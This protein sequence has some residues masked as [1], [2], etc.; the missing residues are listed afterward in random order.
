M[1]QLLIAT[2]P[3]GSGNHLWSKIFSESVKVQGWSELTKEYWVGHGDEPFV[4]V[5]E[6]PSIFSELEWPHEYYF[7]SI[8][9]PYIKIGGPRLEDDNNGRTP[10]YKEFIESAKHA[11]FNVSVCIIG[12]DKN[13]LK[14]Q[15]LRLRGDHTTS[16]LLDIIDQ[17][18]FEYNP[19]FLSTELL[20]LYGDRYLKSI[21]KQLNFPI[22]VGAEK[23]AD[24]L[25]DNANAK[26]LH[27]VEHYWLDDHMKSISH[28]NGNPNN[29]NKYKKGP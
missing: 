10:R 28:K 14:F 3:Q 18:L 22:E 15:Q 5:W 16:R 8:S 9:C 11:G 23:L 4:E 12:R 25:K 24:I 29:P 20:Y 7:T 21:S 26:Y 2:G 1:K 17:E 27:P 6:N 19:V 13:I